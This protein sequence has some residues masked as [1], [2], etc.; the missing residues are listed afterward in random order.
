MSA[1]ENPSAAVAAPSDQTGAP[2]K[3]EGPAPRK[4]FPL[5][6]TFA[7][8][9]GF[10]VFQN[11]EDTPAALRGKS[12]EVRVRQMPMRHAFDTFKLQEQG[13]ELLEFVVVHKPGQEPLPPN[14]TDHLVYESY[15]DLVERAEGVNFFRGEGEMKR[16]LRLRRDLQ[17]RFPEVSQML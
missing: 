16:I 12:L 9:E 3:A 17:E 4:T 14:W 11:Y 6:T 2:A 1:N 5:A 8:V 7:G 13:A 15:L 10:A